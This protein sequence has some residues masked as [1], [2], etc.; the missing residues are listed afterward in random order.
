MITMMMTMK[1]Q[2]KR[3]GIRL[4][5]SECKKLSTSLIMNIKT[6][7]LMRKYFKILCSLESYNLC[8][9]LSGMSYDDEENL[10]TCIKY[11]LILIMDIPLQ[12]WCPS[13]WPRGWRLHSGQE[14]YPCIACQGVLPSALALWLQPI[15][16]RS[17]SMQRKQFY[18]S[19]SND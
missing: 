10:T 2:K 5:K 9:N 16:K 3:V 13:Q 18:S 1:P 6:Q 7:I 8:S 14:T 4:L 15:F 19:K 17:N 12:E 11:L